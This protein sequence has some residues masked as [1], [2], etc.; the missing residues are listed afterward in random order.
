MIGRLKARGPLVN[1]PVALLIGPD[2]PIARVPDPAGDRAMARRTI[3]RAL[4]LQ[5]LGRHDA[6][7]RLE[8]A[9]RDFFAISDLLADKLFLFC[10]EPRGADASVG[11]FVIAA[12]AKAT[13]APL[14]EA[15]ES[16]PNLVAYG[17]RILERFF[18]AG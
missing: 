7:E 11:A 18:P 3:R 1:L 16:R 10:D 13:V 6:A 4:R 17:E 8:L 9:K 14:R 5:G 15:A 12:L 2:V